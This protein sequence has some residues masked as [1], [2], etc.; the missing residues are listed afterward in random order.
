MEKTM[1]DDVFPN[2][3]RLQAEGFID[4]ILNDRPPTPSGQDGINALRVIMA[5]EESAQS[6]MPVPIKL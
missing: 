6:G 5:A 2:M 4:A 3:I 1:N